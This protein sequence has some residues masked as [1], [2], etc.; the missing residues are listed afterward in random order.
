MTNQP[1]SPEV[2]ENDKI[3]GLLSYVISLVVPIIILLS[4]NKNRPFLRYHAIQSLVL[5]GA[6]FIVTLFI[7]CPLTIILTI[8]GLGIGGLCSL[9]L[10][11]IAYAISI[12]YG[13]Q[14]YQG[15][16]VEIPGI[17]NFMKSQGW[18]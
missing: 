5:S 12:Y 9:P 3:M 10:Y 7:G 14:A 2:T 16:Y 4:D 1:V 6:I 11:L 17:T 8:V 13:V 18:V 15:N